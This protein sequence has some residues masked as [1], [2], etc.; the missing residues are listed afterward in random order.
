MAK[1]KST[2]RQT[3]VDKILFIVFCRLLFVFLYFLF[4]PLH[5]LRFLLL[6]L[7]I[8]PLVS[9]NCRAKLKNT[10]EGHGQYLLEDRILQMLVYAWLRD[11]N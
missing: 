8:T 1:I 7:L 11:L 4:W 5:C 6:I 3:I 2:K 9:S 10:S